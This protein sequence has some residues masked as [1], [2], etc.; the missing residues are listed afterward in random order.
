M[1]RLSS[2]SV[3]VHI[4]HE[5]IFF[6]A[7]LLDVILPVLVFGPVEPPP[8]SLHLPL[9]LDPLRLQ[10]VPA[11]VLAPQRGRVFRSK[12]LSDMLFTFVIIIRAFSLG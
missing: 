8:C 4:A 3:N 12:C 2:F 1:K 10:G 11:R 7:F 9:A 5:G 6:P